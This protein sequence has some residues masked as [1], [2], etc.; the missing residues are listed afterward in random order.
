MHSSKREVTNITLSP[1]RVEALTDGVFAIVMTILVLQLTVPVIAEGS[2]H[3]EL[4]ERL[5]DMWPKFLS[6]VVT[7]LMLGVMWFH[8]HRQ[9]SWIKQSDSILVWTNI[10]YLMFVAL[11]PFSTSMVGEFIEERIPVFI[12]GGN[13]IACWIFRYILWS[14]ATGNYRLVD[15]NI[16]PREIR[17]PKIIYPIAIAV[18]M[19]GMGIAFLNT[20]ASICIYA[21]MLTFL[22]VSSAF[23]YQ[24]SAIQKSAK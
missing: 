7:F 2:V 21:L 10:I 20:I 23:L 1:R 15:R 16:D 5:L 18:F 24:V 3:A 19:M 12:Y 11:L 14:Y 13:F 22:I 17:M 6:Y 4:G 8:H 9:F